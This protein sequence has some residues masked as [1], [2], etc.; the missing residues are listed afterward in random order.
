MLEL[1]IFYF[2]QHLASR[3][4]HQFAYA[5][6]VC[7]VFAVYFLV[8]YIVS[9]SA[10]LQLPVSFFDS[11]S[12]LLIA[13][14]FELLVSSSFENSTLTVGTKKTFVDPYGVNKRMNILSSCVLAT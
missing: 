5:S 14:S 13:L 11:V 9:A 1:T 4:P 3:S 7:S 12:I 2:C 10:W 8:V 6:Y